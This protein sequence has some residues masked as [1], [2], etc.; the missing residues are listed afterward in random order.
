MTCV[1]E[2]WYQFAFKW[3]PFVCFLFV[4]LFDFIRQLIVRG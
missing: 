2:M 1:K 4:S 3:N